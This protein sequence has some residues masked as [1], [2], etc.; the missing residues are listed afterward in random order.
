M[1]IQIAL[2]LLAASIPLTALIL[3]FSTMVSPVQFVKLE[4]EFHLFRDE[5][6]EDL[7]KI[8]ANLEKRE[9]EDKK[10]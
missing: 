1:T 4:T 7:K 6:R 8:M 3:K 9:N 10:S 2:S 5:V